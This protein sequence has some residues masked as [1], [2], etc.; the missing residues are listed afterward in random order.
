MFYKQ[1]CRFSGVS[2]YVF[3]ILKIK[4]KKS[5]VSVCRVSIF[6]FLF[7]LWND[8]QLQPKLLDQLVW[9]FVWFVWPLLA[10]TYHLQKIKKS[11]K[12]REREKNVYHCTG[13]LILED[14]QTLHIPKNKKLE[15]WTQCRL[16]LF[17]LGGYFSL[18]LVATSLS[19]YFEEN[20]GLFKKN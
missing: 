1:G 2:Q 13:C 3:L 20:G 15:V 17:F 19:G 6:S 8:V 18:S 10:T 11:M 9:M 12:K 14:L 7:L 16:L 4:T 5:P